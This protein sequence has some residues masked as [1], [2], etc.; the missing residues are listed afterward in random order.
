MFYTGLDPRTMKSVYI[1]RDPREK[2]MQRAL[3]Q[4]FIPKNRPLVR[5]ALR[6]ADRDDLIGF[7]KNC[8]VPPEGSDPA[9]GRKPAR[10]AES[11]HSEAKRGGRPAASKNHARSSDRRAD[12][13]RGKGK[14]R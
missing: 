7:G 9:N 10:P 14:K 6:K 12:A 3:M 2:A 13:S 8:L 4:Y 11:G 1:P 5:E